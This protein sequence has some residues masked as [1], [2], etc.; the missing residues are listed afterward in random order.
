[1]FR[2]SVLIYVSP[3]LKLAPS[4]VVFIYYAV[5]ICIQIGKCFKARNRNFSVRKFNLIAEKFTAV[6]YLSIVVAVENKKS[7][8]NAYPCSFFSKAV[9]VQIK[10]HTI[11]K[12]GK[13]NSQCTK[14]DSERIS[15][16]L[17]ITC[18][19]IFVIERIQNF[20]PNYFSQF[21]TQNATSK[22]SCG[23]CSPTNWSRYKTSCNKS[24][25]TNA[26]KT[27]CTCTTCNTAQC[28]HSP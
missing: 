23:N 5:F 25:H 12:C 20:V 8:F 9:L 15:G 18:I 21:A 13:I 28:T 24:S 7:V 16:R 1:M 26:C 19:G 11:F 22:T 4:H 17:C 3:D 6:V 10:V 27:T 2:Y 14:V